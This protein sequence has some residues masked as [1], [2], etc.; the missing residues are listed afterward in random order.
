MTL[1]KSI[2]LRFASACNS[3]AFGFLLSILGHAKDQLHHEID[4]YSVIA[5]TLKASRMQANM[6]P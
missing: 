4:Q 5:V 2:G 3:A 6:L 1:I